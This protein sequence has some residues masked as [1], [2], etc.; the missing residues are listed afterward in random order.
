MHL[1][2]L[3]GMQIFQYLYQLQFVFIWYL[4]KGLFC[5]SSGISEVPI[6]HLELVSACLLAKLVQWTICPASYHFCP[7][8]NL[9]LDTM[10]VFY[11]INTPPYKLKLVAAISE[12]VTLSRYR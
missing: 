11:R 2:V 7:L 1:Q 10:N 6:P 3:I 5:H 9:P 12:W 4:A 8:I